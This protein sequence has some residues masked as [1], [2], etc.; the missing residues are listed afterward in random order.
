MPTKRVPISRFS[1]ALN[2]AQT[3][4]LHGSPL[5]DDADPVAWLEHCWSTA[6]HR[7][8][9]DMPAHGRPTARQLWQEHGEAVLAAWVRARP[10]TRPPAWWRCTAP[11]SRRRLGGAGE[12]ARNGLH[13]GVPAEWLSFDP[14]DPPI[15]ESEATFL[16]RLDLLLPGEARRLKPADFNPQAI[17][18]VF[19]FGNE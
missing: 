18:Q 9:D 11:G 19:D 14:Q 5:P 7:S 15:F 16:R 17:T 3:A 8:P 1:T 13:L 4:F 10:G 6:S 12:P 2:P